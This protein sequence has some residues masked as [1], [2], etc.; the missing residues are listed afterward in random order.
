MSEQEN[1]PEPQAES[2]E[3]LAESLRAEIEAKETMAEAKGVDRQL[4]RVVAFFA[5]AAVAAM[6]VALC[7]LL[8]YLVLSG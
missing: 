8:I 5:V 4:L 3:A 7:G 1:G 6:L 2:A